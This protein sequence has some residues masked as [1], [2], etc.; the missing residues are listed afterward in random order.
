MIA[1]FLKQSFLRQ[2][3]IKS[4]PQLFL[5]Y[6]FGQSNRVATIFTKGTDLDQSKYDKQR[7]E[8]E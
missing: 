1:H 3:A 2:P 7:A 6:N 8:E 4:P 5:R